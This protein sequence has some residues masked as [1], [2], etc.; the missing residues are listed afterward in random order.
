MLSRAVKNDSMNTQARQKVMKSAELQ[1][2]SVKICV[3]VSA[4]GTVASCLMRYYA[5]PLLLA[6]QFY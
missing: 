1:N 2:E 5:A 3:E 4:F 6:R